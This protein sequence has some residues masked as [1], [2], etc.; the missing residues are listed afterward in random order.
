M[1][2]NYMKKWK[3]CLAL[4]LLSMGVCTS[5]TQPSSPGAAVIFPQEKQPGKAKLT[6]EQNGE[7]TL[8][9]DL[10]TAKF[11]AQDGKLMFA[12]APELG[13]QPGT[14]IFKIRLGDGT[15]VLASDM[16]LEG[17]QAMPLK[18]DKNAVKGAKKFDGHAI[19]ANFAYGDLDIVW[20]AVLRDGSHY[21]RTELDLT[22]K[23]DVAMHS[24][25]PMIYNVDNQNGKAVP[26]VVGNTRGAVIASSRIFAGL[27]TPTG[28]NTAG[29]VQAGDDN[30]VP[31]KTGEMNVAWQNKIGANEMLTGTWNPTDWKGLTNIPKRINELGFYGDDVKNIVLNLEVNEPGTLATEFLY[32]SGSCGLSIVG[33]DVLDADNNVVASDYH[34]GFAGGKLEKNVYSLNVPYNGQ[35]KLR[36]FCENKTEENVSN[37][38]IHVKLKVAEKAE[39]AKV[40]ESITPI[41]GL[42]SRNTTLQKGKT[43]NVGAVVGI[44]AEGQARRSF[45]AYSERERAVPWRAMPVYISWYE[46]NIDRNNDREYTTNMNVE[47]CTDV[48]AEWKKQFFDK[49]KTNVKAFVWDDGWDFYGPWTFNKNFPNGFSEID[50]VARLMNTGIGAWLG[51]VGGYGRSGDYRRAYWA[52]RGGM[53]LSNPEYYKMFLD[54]CTYMIKNYDFRFFKY[55][56][57]SAQF[58]AVGPDPGTRGE[59]NAE[60]IIDIERETR[61]IKEDIFLNTTVGT[62]ASPFWFQFTDAVWRQ[63]ADY[64]EIGNQGSDRERWI[65]YRDRLVYQNYVQNSPLCPI[66]MM[67]THGFILSRWGAVSKDMDYDGIVREMRCA[68]ACGSGMV[69]LYND[70]KLMNEING[71]ALWKDLADCIAWQEANADVLPDIHWVGGNPWDGKKANIYGWAAWN[72]KKAVLTLRNPSA[73]EQS[74]TLTLR[75]ALDIPAYVKTSITLSD[76]FQQE[77][78]AGLATGQKIDIDTPLTITM[79]AS[80]VFIYNGID[81]K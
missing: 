14:E 73:S 2:K 44:I 80:S 68:F 38:D 6:T 37:G 48:V 75:E 55:D 60:A 57:I 74:I 53:Q 13:L 58:S 15:E 22:G 12:G 35:F 50:S 61:K 66:N 51:P 31:V 19:E 69:E 18:G 7:F 4:C 64:S 5:C 32:K 8:S 33:M 40:N 77:A 3:L 43:W 79:P 16:K 39:V 70:Y 47:Q 28:I 25:V 65:T 26:E 11:I 62:W 9:N 45:L 24:I 23:E 81:K 1:K 41:Q 46:L 56:G 49:Y 21:L 42:W 17:V 10:L 52:D 63:E 78:L 67:M 72:A 76:A 30:W 27:E 34:K 71:G 20:R 29:N 36:L 54:A 59:E